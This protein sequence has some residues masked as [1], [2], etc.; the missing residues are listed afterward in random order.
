MAEVP[1]EHIDTPQRYWQNGLCTDETK[2]KLLRKCMQHY[3]YCKKGTA[4]HHKQP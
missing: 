1:Q 3:I 2:T 4:C